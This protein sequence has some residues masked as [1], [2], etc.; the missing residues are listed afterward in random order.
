[1]I[2]DRPQFLLRT[3]EIILL[4]FRQ[5]LAIPML[6]FEHRLNFELVQKSQNC[7]HALSCSNKE[8]SNLEPSGFLS[9]CF[10]FLILI[11][12]DPVDFA[13]LLEVVAHLLDHLGLVPV[14]SEAGYFL[15]FN[16]ITTLLAI[17]A[18]YNLI[19]DTEASLGLNKHLLIH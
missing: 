1:M 8:R 2:E 12:K 9:S 13:K 3:P 16:L 11:N 7:L 10:L 15:K 19:G 5:C 18:L 17:H 6:D 4:L 14:L